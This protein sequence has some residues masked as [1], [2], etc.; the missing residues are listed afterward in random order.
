L[1][2]DLTLQTPVM[3]YGGATTSAVIAKPAPGVEQ[4]LSPPA[5]SNPEDG[6]PDWDTMTAEEKIE[7]NRRRRDAIFG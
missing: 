6:E 3:S 2:E 4:L 1:E 7:Y 5:G